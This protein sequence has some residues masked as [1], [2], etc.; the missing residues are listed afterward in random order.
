CSIIL[1]GINNAGWTC[2]RL[3]QRY[4]EDAITVIALRCFGHSWQA[5][6]APNDSDRESADDDGVIPLTAVAKESS[7]QERIAASCREHRFDISRFF[8]VM[9][10]SLDD[11]LTTEF[12]K[13]H[14]KQF[15]KRPIAW[16]L[17]SSSFTSRS[18]PVFACLL[19]CHRVDAD[20]IQKIRTQYT[21]PLKLRYETEMRG[22]S[23][24][25]AANRTD[26]QAKRAVELEEAIT[27]LQAFDDKLAAIAKSGFG[28]AKLLPTL[29]QYSFDDAMLAM[30]AR[31]LKRLSELLDESPGEDTADGTRE[32]S[33]LDQWQ[34][35]AIE[36]GL[37]PELAGWIAE[38]LSN[39]DHFCSQVGP[40]APDAKKTPDDPTAADVAE[41]IRPET[42]SMQTHSF[43][44]ACGVWWG[45]F[46][47]AVLAPIKER[48]KQLKAEQKEL[49]AEIK[50]RKAEGTKLKGDAAKDESRTAS[51]DGNSSF[52]L[53][54]SSASLKERLDEVK[55]KIKKFTRELNAKSAKAKA[56]RDSI[57]AWR[58]SEPDQWH[59]WLAEGPLFDQVS[60]LDERRTPPKTIAEFIAQESL[61]APDINDGVRVN[62]APLQKAGVLAADVLAAKDVDKA[63]A[64]RAE[65]R[66]DERRWVRE[67]KLPQCGWWAEQ[68]VE[69][70]EMKDEAAAGSLLVAPG[71][72]RP[73]KMDDALYSSAV[74]CEML[75]QRPD[76]IRP[77]ELAQAFCLLIRKDR[78]RDALVDHT[79]RVSGELANKWHVDFD[80]QP[81]PEMLRTLLPDLMSRQFAAY[82]G[83]VLV[84][85]EK[86]VPSKNAWARYDVAMALTAADALPVAERDEIVEPEVQEMIFS[87]RLVG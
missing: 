7:I 39:L 59:D 47:D 12:F 56:I 24:T 83:S 81:Q 18:T 33:P 79:D 46:D 50:R 15:K 23:S 58:S 77:I 52:Q 20:V 21:G 55:A 74:L 8:E 14:I 17:Q 26:N 29:R 49:N 87:L 1:D 42:A 64:D 45:K 4:L 3:E 71:R 30:K 48:I 22:I 65:W 76:G 80:Q 51:H 43:G 54:A 2:Q 35:Q 10:K 86:L 57:Q 60:S 31:W 44:L 72:L 63:I 61:Y 84:P 62:I 38:E 40:K 27:E 16:Q 37:H 9:G 73:S 19:Y 28:P 68:K 13:H 78:L 6:L 66:S 32:A 69:G 67:G 36:T 70:G 5:Q 25:P 82:D 11:W 53:D 34:G 75:L 41:L 85:G